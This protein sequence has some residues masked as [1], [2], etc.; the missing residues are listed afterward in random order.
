MNDKR[1]SYELLELE[2]L[3][4][5]GRHDA[6]E[7]FY[8]KDSDDV[9]DRILIN[10]NSR[11]L[12]FPCDAHDFI[13]ISVDRERDDLLSVRHDL[14]YFRIVELENVLD[15]LFL[16]VFDIAGL[17]AYVDHHTDLF[18]SYGLVGLVGIDPEELQDDV[19]RL[20]KEPYKGL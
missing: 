6:Y 4:L 16:G 14:G 7:V 1:L 12:L 2:R 15:H 13:V 10:G 18:L 11:K 20:C 3:V 9:I 8:V 17:G 5:R 19:C